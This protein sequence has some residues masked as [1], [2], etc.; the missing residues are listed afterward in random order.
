MRI[1]ATVLLYNEVAYQSYGWGL[2][3]PLGNLQTV[4]DFLQDY[5]VDEISIIRPIKQDDS[6]Q[7][8]CKTLIKS[9]G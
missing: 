5:Q 2:L 1:G 9:K 3:R 8:F 7:C 4:V 6:F